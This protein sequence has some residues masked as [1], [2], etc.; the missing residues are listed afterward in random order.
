MNDAF[1]PI[2]DGG[3]PPERIPFPSGNEQLD[4]LLAYYFDL[5]KQYE[6]MRS[7]SL[8]KEY[9]FVDP[10]E[11]PEYYQRMA[12]FQALTDE[13]L[14]V[15]GLISDMAHMS[16]N[17]FLAMPQPTVPMM[18][19]GDEAIMRLVALPKMVRERAVPPDVEIVEPPK[20]WGQ[21]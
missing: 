9:L 12:E 13:L 20:L 15:R 19:E 21:D 2:D 11:N 14:R 8:F 1:L 16:A 7:G 3:V 18:G 5:K 10:E 17:P 6:D 4:R